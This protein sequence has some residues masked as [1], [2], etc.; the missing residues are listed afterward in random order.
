MADLPERSPA[1]SLVIERIARALLEILSKERGR[2]TEPTLARQIAGRNQNKVKAL[3]SLVASGQA[4]RLGAGTKG[5]PF[6]YQAKRAPAPTAPEEV[7]L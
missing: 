2:L 3:R 1:D 4:I 6:Y 5:D 7:I